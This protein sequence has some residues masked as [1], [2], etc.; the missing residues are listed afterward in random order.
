MLRL[1]LSL[2]L[3]QSLSPHLRL[4]QSL[5]PRP[6]LHLHQR[7]LLSPHPRHELRNPH[8]YQPLLQLQRELRFRQVRQTN[9]SHQLYVASLEI[10]A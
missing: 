3:R 1:L 6:R 10:T 4:R 8:R 7:L 2:R 5:S 9:F